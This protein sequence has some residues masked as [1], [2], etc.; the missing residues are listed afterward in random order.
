MPLTAPP[1]YTRVFL[2]VGLGLTLALVVAVYSRSTLP[3]VGDNSHALPHG[4]IYRDGTKSV[5]YGAPKK[6]NSL[7]SYSGNQAWAAFGVFSLT[8]LVLL[9]SWFSRSCAACHQRH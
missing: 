8:G 9:S 6:L 2:C 1:D 5:C 3:F 7:E 4:G